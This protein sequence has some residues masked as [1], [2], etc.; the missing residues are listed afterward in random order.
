MTRR[1]CRGSGQRSLSLIEGDWTNILPLDTGYVFTATDLDAGAAG[2][3]ITVDDSRFQIAADGRLQLKAGQSFTNAEAVAR[4]ITLTVTATDGAL[5]DTE[6]LT[7][8]VLRTNPYASSITLGSPN[9]RFGEAAD[10]GGPVVIGGITVSD[11]GIDGDPAPI[12]AS[13]LALAGAGAE[14]FEI[15][16]ADGALQLRLKQGATILAAD[17]TYNLTL[18]TVNTGNQPGGAEA[19]LNVA[20][21]VTDEITGGYVRDVDNVV[22]R[23]DLKSLVDQ[24]FRL[25]ARTA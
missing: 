22:G 8:P 24:M 9:L 16:T 14:N 7:I 13:N 3:Q 25:P 6:T 23:P 21:T 19:S 18:T 5:S 10:D 4:S 2:L 1:F 17:Q 12:A 15:V 20:V 11:T